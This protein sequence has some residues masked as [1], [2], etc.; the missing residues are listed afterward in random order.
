MPIP[1]NSA[2]AAA[3]V[4]GPFSLW[5]GPA[6]AWALYDF[7]YSLFSFLLVVRFLP[8]WIIDDLDRPDW[9]IGLTQFAV[10][11]FVLVAMPLAGALADQLGRRRPLLATFTLVAAAASA[12]LGVLPVDGSVLPVLAVAAVAVAFGQLAFAQYDPLLADVA[13]ERRRGL[14]SGLAVALGFA[15]IVVG[16]GV[17]AELVVGEG[18]K[19]RAFAPAGLLY[20]LF[21]LPALVLIRERGRV[22]GQ[23]PSGVVRR[24]FG[25]FA[26]SPQELRRYRS[27]FRFV[28]G[29]FLYSDAI[30]T[31]SAFLTVYM[32][33]LG[34]FSE[35][36]KNVAIAVAV[37]A[38]AAGAVM[39]GRLVERFGPKRPLLAVLPA[40]AASALLSALV[41]QPWT[42]WLA[43]PVAGVA[44]GVVWTADRVFMLRLTPEELRGQFFGFFNL[45]S[46]VASAFGPLVIWSGTVWLLY[47]QTSWLSA[48]GASRVAVAGLAATALLGWAVIR[49]LS[50]ERRE[51][52]LAVAPALP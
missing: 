36:E 20:V 3:E 9:Y 13:P 25:Q 23:V 51:E 19:Q 31:L 24:A 40:F 12:A 35:R 34:G 39:A 30:A 32:T 10:V 33:R 50:D 15:G 5:R 28:A 37:L 4:N 17:V 49:P 43:T 7:A 2:Y 44:L 21:A 8:A 11:L 16:L 1:S 42:I 27:V 47:E 38:A 52:D 29:R 48:L 45:A 46:R 6:L 14:V 41:G 26:R 22:Q 18:S